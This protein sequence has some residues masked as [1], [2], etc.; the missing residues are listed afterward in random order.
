MGFTAR[1][2]VVPGAAARQG[3]HPDWLGQFTLHCPDG[4]GMAPMPEEFRHY[5][6]EAKENAEPPGLTKSDR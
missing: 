6:H 5:L 2:S 1:P 3:G 4:F